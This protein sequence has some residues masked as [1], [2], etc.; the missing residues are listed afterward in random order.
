MRRLVFLLAVFSAGCTATILLRPG[1][2]A[3]IP[4][5]RPDTVFAQAEGVRVWATG[6]WSGDPLSLP[7]VM[8]PVH[9]AFENGSGR[10]LRVSAHEAT[11]VGSSGFRY[12]ALPPFPASAPVSAVEAEGQVVLADYHPATPVKKPH[13]I[14]PRPPP[15]R[16]FVAPPIYPWYPGIGVWPHPWVWGVHHATLYANWPAPLPTRDMLERALPEGVLEPG[17]T[18][19]GFLYF[20]QVAREAAVTLEVQLVD[21]E[22]QAPFGV[23]RLP[24]VVVR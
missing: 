19:S 10:R 13:P 14:H 20:Q 15:V 5:A 12:S 17:G 2:G 4:A 16:F 22:T 18:V 1:P 8:T 7:D 6:G 9:V 23:A 21:A 3:S 11:L 24:F